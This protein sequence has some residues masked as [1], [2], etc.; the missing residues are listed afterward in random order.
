MINFRGLENSG[1]MST[2]SLK[3][4]EKQ[5]MHSTV[6]ISVHKQIDG[7]TFSLA[8]SERRSIKYHFPRSFPANNVFVAY[9]TK[10]DFELYADK[11]EKYVFPVLLGLDEENDLQ[12]IEKVE[13]VDSQSGEVIYEILPHDQKIQ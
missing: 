8:P 11:I 7:Y 5:K 2:F 9:D 12:K 1:A 4:V 6:R 3:F 10:S 13:F